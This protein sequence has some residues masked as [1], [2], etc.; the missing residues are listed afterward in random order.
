MICLIFEVISRT[1]VKGAVTGDSRW[2]VITL[3]IGIRALFMLLASAGLH[4]SV[5][6]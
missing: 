5:A 1:L 3:R 6:L 2:I 4:E